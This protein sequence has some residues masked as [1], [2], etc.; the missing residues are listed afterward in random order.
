MKR[1]SNFYNKCKCKISGVFL[2]LIEEEESQE[3]SQRG[4]GAIFNLTLRI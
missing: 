1:Y 2:P 4:G 3:A